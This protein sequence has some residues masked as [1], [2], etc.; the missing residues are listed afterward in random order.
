MLFFFASHFLNVLK[1]FQFKN[2]FVKTICCLQTLGK[3]SVRIRLI[4]ISDF[5]EKK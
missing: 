2:N 5:F 3:C 1:S 4:C